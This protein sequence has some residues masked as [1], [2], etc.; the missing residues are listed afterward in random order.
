MA[1]LT[2]QSIATSYEQLLSLPSGGL[3]GTSLVAITDGDSDTAC[4]LQ[5]STTK[6]MITGD[7]STLYFYD[8]GG[9]SI[10]ADSSGKLTIAAAAEIES[11]TAIFDLNA[12][13]AVTLDGVPV[14]I[15]STG[16]ITLDSSTDIVLDADGDNITMK[17][18]STGSG[19][20]F[21]Q[22]GTGDYTIKNL[23]SNK[24]II[25]NV[26][27]GG[28]D[29]EVMRIDGSSSMVGIGTTA[30]DGMLDIYSSS[31]GLPNVYIQNSSTTNQ[32]GGALI[33]TNIDTDT[34]LGNDVIV[35]EILAKA[36][37]P[38]DDALLNA[39]R[40]KFQMDGSGAT[41]DINGKIV[42]ETGTGNSTLTERLT[43][44]A[45]GNIGVGT[46]TPDTKLEVVGSFAANGPSSTFVT[47]SSGDTSPDVSTGNIFK[48]HSDGVTIDQFD[49]GICGQIITIISGGATVYDVTS[50]ELKGGTTNITT[51]A[52]DVTMWV[53]ESATVWHLI[54]WMD[55]SIDLSSGG[56]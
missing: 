4:A 25:F 42:F 27:E 43:I 8:E 39:G 16:D 46:L 15:T 56:F 3:D 5:V 33:F 14:T 10:N 55:L 45:T 31:S 17:A 12:S 20:D 40:I 26:N 1:T 9:E 24:D 36:G 2:G 7:G 38:S 37:D 49:G 34:N 51:D 35:G 23:T 28:S 41:N 54:S 30:P 44:K 19:L 32:T 48:S 13:G 53:C 47:M 21:I 52:G 6:V 29:T 11:N 18:G 22:S 50:S